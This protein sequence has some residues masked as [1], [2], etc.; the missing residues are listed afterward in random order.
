MLGALALAAMGVYVLAVPIALIGAVAFIGAYLARGKDGPAQVV[1]A[2]PEP[3]GTPRAA[4]QPGTANE[5]VEA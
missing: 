1:G 5:R 4:P 3:T 2:G